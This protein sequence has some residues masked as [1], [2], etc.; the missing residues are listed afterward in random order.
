MKNK[1]GASWQ[2]AKSTQDSLLLHWQSTPWPVLVIIV[3]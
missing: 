1:L 3:L 2:K